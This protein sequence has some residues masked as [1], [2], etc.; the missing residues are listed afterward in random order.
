MVLNLY[1]PVERH[2]VQFHAGKC[3]R[4]GNLLKPDLRKGLIYMDQGDDQLM[5]FYWKERKSGSQPEDDLIIFPD[6]AEMVRVPECTTGRVIMLK[7]K[8]SSQ[9]LF[10]WMQHKN[11]RGD[12]TFINSVN[13]AINTP[14][15][16]D[17]AMDI[18]SQN[19]E[20]ELMQR[21]MGSASDGSLT[22]QS[23]MELFQQ[24]RQQHDDHDD[25]AINDDNTTNATV[26]PSVPDTAETD[27]TATAAPEQPTP[28]Q[29]QEQEQ[30]QEQEQEAP[31][32]AAEPASASAP[33]AESG[34]QYEQLR[35]I[36]AGFQQ[37]Q[38]QA[39]PVHLKDVLNKDVLAT[40]LTDKDVCEAM[41]P[42]LPDNCEHTPDQLR[43]VLLSPQFQQALHGFTGALQ[44]GQL[45]PLTQQFGLDPSAALGPEAFLRGIERQVRKD[46]TD[47][48]G[49]HDM[50]AH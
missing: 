10:Y 4:Q 41:Y 15:L 49:D 25:D 28:M 35:N 19:I 44:S 12:D 43:Q 29:E 34:D 37:Q 26:A 46:D 11:D 31:A 8:T 39:S 22:E 48:D 2:L 18:D 50:D 33:A 32:P 7:F 16:D 6:E 24:A 47:K 13:R 5:H 20:M 36:L 40:L 30:Q 42:H 27:T 9:R 1:Q 17:T 23:L 21:L 45:G 3:I 38:Q 14:S